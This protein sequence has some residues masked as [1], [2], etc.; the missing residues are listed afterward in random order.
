MIKQGNRFWSL[1]V[2]TAL[3]TGFVLSQSGCGLDGLGGISVEI[4]GVDGVLND[5]LGGVGNNGED[6]A[7]GGETGG[8]DGQGSGQ[9]VTGDQ[10]TGGQGGT[11]Q[12]D[13]SPVQGGD[14]SYEPNN[15][16]QEAR[17]L[18]SGSYDLM[19]MDSDWFMIDV[20][21]G[22]PI[23]IEIEG[24]SGDMDLF[25]YDDP[26]SED[27]ILAYSI[28]AGTN[29][30]VGGEI[31]PGR[32]YIEVWPYEDQTGAYTLHLSLPDGG[33]VGNPNGGGGGSQGGQ[34]QG[35]G[36]QDAYAM[37][38]EQEFGGMNL[39]YTHSDYNGGYNAENTTNIYLCSNGSFIYHEYAATSGPGFEPSVTNI[40][41]QGTWRVV[42]AEGVYALEVT[43]TEANDPNYMG[44][45]NYQIEINNQG[46]FLNGQH[47]YRLPDKNPYCN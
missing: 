20:A 31:D 25:I 33:S 27:G 2:I 1:T 4:P 39:R 15:T 6:A 38:L 36:S 34:E 10:G 30:Y 14:D 18:G 26:T 44:V 41:A 28:E 46:L 35:Q 22:G 21:V 23:S 12:N 8:D 19:G 11:G 32:Y 16:P 3:A 24:S 9:P 45:F 40:E 17:V 13:G 43:S 42:S 29:D 7:P 5:L 47:F 37:Q